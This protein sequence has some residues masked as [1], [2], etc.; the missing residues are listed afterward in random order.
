MTKTLLQDYENSIVNVKW[1]EREDLKHQAKYIVD[2]I[3][4]EKDEDIIAGINEALPS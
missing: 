4:N 2:Y 1:G 3:I